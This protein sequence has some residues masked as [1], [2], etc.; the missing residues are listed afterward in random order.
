MWP[1]LL[2]HL[3]LS[4]M[5]Y[6]IWDQIMR[7]W[8][9]CTLWGFSMG[10]SFSI[11]QNI[12]LNINIC[13]K[14]RWFTIYWPLFLRHNI[15]RIRSVEAQHNDDSPSRWPHSLI[16][17]KSFAP[18]VTN[19]HPPRSKTRYANINHISVQSDHVGIKKTSDC[20]RCRSDACAPQGLP[21]LVRAIALVQFPCH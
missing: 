6:I 16:M 21:K 5:P 17:T 14:S 18:C 1:R 15:S 3:L 13:S 19:L 7:F 10:L 11:P 20:L 12:E 2:N 4:P 8:H 9:H